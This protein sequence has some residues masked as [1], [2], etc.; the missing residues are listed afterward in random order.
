MRRRAWGLV[1]LTLTAAI[2]CILLGC[3]FVCGGRALS[4][5]AD[6][7]SPAKIKAEV[8][9]TAA[10][11]DGML[12][13]GAASGRDFRLFLPSDSPKKDRNMFVEWKGAKKEEVWRSDIIAL[14]VKTGAGDPPSRFHYDHTWQTLTPAV[15]FLIYRQNGDRFSLTDWSIIV[16]AHGFVRIVERT[17]GRLVSEFRSYEKGG[18]MDKWDR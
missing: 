17:S 5:W 9:R 8:Y 11:L 12:Y 3:V 13:R 10:W 4:G 16:S 18:G 6:P 14:K 2:T 15:T 7:H 1:E